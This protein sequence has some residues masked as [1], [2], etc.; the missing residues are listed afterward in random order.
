MRC[1]DSA[2]DA[3][4]CQD[5]AHSCVTFVELTQSNVSGNVSAGPF[6]NKNT[7]KCGTSLVF[8]YAADVMLPSYTT[9]DSPMCDP[10]LCE[11]VVEASREGGDG[12]YFEYAMVIPFGPHPS[13]ET[14]HKD[15]RTVDPLWQFAEQTSEH[16]YGMVTLEDGAAPYVTQ[17]Q[18]VPKNTVVCYKN[19]RE[20]LATALETADVGDQAVA[21]TACE[22]TPGCT[23]V[24]TGQNP[25]G[26]AYN[27]MDTLGGMPD[28]ASVYGMCQIG[29]AHV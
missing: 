24:P 23:W 12:S 28:N 8:P 7:R 25:P 22:A 9:Y 13:R 5:G 26:V 15:S 6:L 17:P 2:G 18:C 4:Q 14:E 20:L 11:V 19:F 10:D 1:Y 27:Y 21:A 3:T 16:M 29:R